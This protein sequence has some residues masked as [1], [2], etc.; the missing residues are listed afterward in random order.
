MGRWGWPGRRWRRE[1]CE[2][3]ILYENI[4]NKNKYEEIGS[5]ENWDSNIKYC[6]LYGK[7]RHFSKCKHLLPIS[8]LGT[9]HNELTIGTLLGVYTHVYNFA[10]LNSP[11]GEEIH[12]VCTQMHGYIECDELL[13]QKA[14]LKKK[15]LM[16]LCKVGV[17][18]RSYG[19]WNA[20]TPEGWRWDS[21]DPIWN[22][23]LHTDRR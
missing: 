17:P 13:K 3:N 4:F 11:K 23:Q 14:G 8:L 20:L 1:N 15:D 16:R 9:Y 18:W 7:H 21:T 19:K 12:D 6:S 5:L 2:K 10:A 22:V